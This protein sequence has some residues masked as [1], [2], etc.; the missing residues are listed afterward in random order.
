ML[1]SISPPKSFRH[2]S[3][4]IPSTP[5]H[6]SVARDKRLDSTTYFAAMM[7]PVMLTA[8]GDSRSA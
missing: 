8:A 2:H 6:A 3:Y 7:H 4:Q 1:Q 5:H